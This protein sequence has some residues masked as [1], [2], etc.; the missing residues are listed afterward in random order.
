[1]PSL[2]LIPSTLNL[3]SIT[4]STLAS[5]LHHRPTSCALHSYD[6]IRVL[7]CRFDFEFTGGHIDGAVNLVD[8]TPHTIDALLM[9]AMGCRLCVVVHCEFSAHRG[10]AVYRAL[11]KRDRE[12]NGIE[13]FPHLYL[14]ELYVLHGGYAAFHKAHPEL[15]RP[16]P[17]AFVS[18]ADDR[19]HA[20][21]KERW[22]QRKADTRGVSR[23]REPSPVVGAVI[24]PDAP[25]LVRTQTMPLCFTH[26]ALEPQAGEAAAFP[27]SGGGG[28]GE[29]EV[30]L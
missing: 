13:H 22:K 5:L 30:L 14:P 12:L 7:D 4:P 3:P 8:L 18:M 20:Q 27:V 15:C 11:R 19:F 25:T 6:E 10:P 2:P 23:S 16:Q 21:L 29:D 1:M 24:L 9:E 26:P 28:G 17:G